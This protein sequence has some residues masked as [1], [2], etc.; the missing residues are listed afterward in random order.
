MDLKQTLEAL[1]FLA[2][3]EI[4]VKKEKKFGIISQN[5]LGITHADL[6]KIAKE[7]G[8]NNE[9]GVQLFD[10]GIYEAK[11]LCSKIYDYKCLT[12]NQLETWV[13]HFDNWE[14][15]DSFCMGQFTKSRF[16][17]QKI[18]EWTTRV[19]EF[20]KRAG[21]AMMAAYSFHHK[22]DENIIF[23]N[24]LPIIE[25]ECEDERLYVK[26]AINWA[27][28]NIGKRNKDLQVKAIEVAENI[29][30]RDCKGAKWIAK[31]AIRELT[32][33]KV[34]VLDYPRGIYRG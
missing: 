6:K 2:N 12:E 10:T 33:G 1:N 23:E 11:I 17:L 20:E 5:A 24:F 29:L 18:E 19:P 32:A 30:K 7:V 4:I 13:K 8:I 15:C 14:I 31:D 21:F 27:L 9:L 22:N 3:P 34:N 16:A 25:R 26:K 28:R